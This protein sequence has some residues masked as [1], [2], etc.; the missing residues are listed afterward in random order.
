MA[1]LVRPRLASD[2]RAVRRVARASWRAAL[3]GRAPAAFLA[4]IWRALYGRERLVLGLVEARRDAFVAEREGVVVGYAD[5][6]AGDGA[7]YHLA[8]VYVAPEAWGA[9]AGRALVDAVL[10][11]ARAR[12]AAHVELEVDVANV[13]GLAWWERRGFAR[14]GVGTYELPPFARATIRLA[15]SSTP[16]A[17]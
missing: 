3:E 4:A 10:E 11:A 17:S 15:R 5:G 7:A 6:I 12:G 9:G 8:R 13:R 14:T 2:T 1:V 16:L